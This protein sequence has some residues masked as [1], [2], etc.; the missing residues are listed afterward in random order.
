MT[1]CDNPSH[2][3]LEA[4]VLRHAADL[5]ELRALCERLAHA[6]D[7]IVIERDEARTQRDQIQ[8]NYASAKIEMSGL[9]AAIQQSD[10]RLRALVRR[11]FGASSERLIADE[12]YIPEVLAALR[13]QGV[14]A[15][16]GT[17]VV[18][19]ADDLS[20]TT[21]PGAPPATAG[22]ALDTT[23]NST[24]ASATGA[25]ATPEKKRRRPVNAG[26]RKPLPED[27]ERRDS[28]YV[29]PAD[30]PALRHAVSHETIGTTVVE[31]WHI[32]KVDLH[33]ERITC[34][35]VRLVLSHDMSCQ[36]T[37][38]PPAVV[39][40]GQVSDALLVQSAVD[41]VVDH[42]PAYRQEQRALRVGVHI[43]RAKLCRWHMCLAEFL[44]G[45]A[46]AIFTE[47][48]AS[49]VI[50]ID[51]SVHRQQVPGRHTC[52][53]SRIWAVSA[54]IG[55]F[56]LHTPT[57]EGKWI[58]DLLADYGGGVMGDAYAGHHDLLSRL[59]I[60]AL[61]CWAHV[62]RKF[63]DA[64]DDKRRTIM[65]ALIAELYQIEESLAVST[66]HERVR[67]RGLRAPEV[68]ARIK[69]TLDT[70]QEQVLPASGIGHRPGSHLYAQTVGRP[71]T[72]CD[73]RRGAD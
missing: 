5:G 55:I 9:L 59:D 16:P 69:A 68:L 72:L 73:H 20:G 3:R 64:A 14:T 33:I 12:G 58:S 44:Q 2:A 54:P 23:G 1:Q 62:R 50:G 46:D 43:P 63:F 4:Q 38:S 19:L 71:G 52:R 65:I 13:D 47:V 24:P 40:R 61:F 35:V 29:P 66:P 17:A 28:T 48:C 39:D 56:Y 60:I 15:I 30:H 57:R 45:V 7:V 11:E 22:A 37:L 51:D 53:Q 34:P 8:C 25:A 70:W 42:L 18:T 27:I 36:Q 67:A 49:P 41:K 10:E 21:P 6:H 26:G 31:R 32:G